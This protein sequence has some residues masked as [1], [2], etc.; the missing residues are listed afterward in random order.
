MEKFECLNCLRIG[1]LSVHGACSHC[2][3]QSVVSEEVIS[4]NSERPCQ[5]KMS[6]IRPMTTATSPC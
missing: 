4:L 2:G 5:R 3:S 6:A 1:V